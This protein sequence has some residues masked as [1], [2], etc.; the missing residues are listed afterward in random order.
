[1]SDPDWMQPATCHRNGRLVEHDDA[2]ERA[3][4]YSVGNQRDNFVPALRE[5][6]RVQRMEVLGPEQ[7]ELQAPGYQRTVNTLNTSHWD[8][9][10]GFSLST[11][12]LAIAVGVGALLI[13][14]FF[15]GLDLLSLAAVVTLFLGFLATWLIAWLGF[16]LAS[17]DGVNL[18]VAWSHFRL[19]RHEQSAR[20]RRMERDE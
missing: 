4:T 1:M 13:S 17:P 2:P 20:L 12:P 5:P 6:V 7:H 10:K 11:V 14:I 18:F 3:P 16:Q 8:R 19:L 15:F 9:A